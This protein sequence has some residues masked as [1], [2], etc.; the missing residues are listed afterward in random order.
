MCS[1]LKEYSLIFPSAGVKPPFSQLPF[2]VLLKT[3][4]TVM[5]FSVLAVL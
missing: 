1:I 3:D 4:N 2:F 5:A